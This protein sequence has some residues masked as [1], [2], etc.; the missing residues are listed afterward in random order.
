M[1]EL[2]RSGQCL[3]GAIRYSAQLSAPEI[4]ACHC[5]QCQRWT[6]GSPYLCVHTDTVS[7]DGTP[8]IAKFHASAH[9]ERAFCPTCGT[10]LY[11]TMQ[12]KPPRSIAL[13]TLDDQSDLKVT[14]EIF[15]DYRAPWLAP[16]P[17]AS[18]ATEAEVLA[19]FQAVLAEQASQ[20]AKTG[21]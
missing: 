9:G 1:A 7:F 5:R 17:G 4:Q 11:W 3:C 21:E 8:E 15:V 14:E 16:W 10:T 19:Q 6:G 13:G 18:Q 2:E 20:S 12:G